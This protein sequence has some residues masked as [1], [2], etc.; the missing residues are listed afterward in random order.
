M[1]IKRDKL[2]TIGNDA[3][4][5]KGTSHGVLTGI[6]YLAPTDVSGFQVC[7]KASEGCK[8]ACLF[9]AGRGVYENVRDGRINRTRWFFEDR[10]SFMAV[11][12]ADIQFLIR[13]AARM[14]A[15]PAVRLN[16]TSDIAWEKIRCVVDGVE[17]RNLM[18]AFPDLQFYDYTKIAG[19]KAALALPNYHLTFSMAEDNDADAQRALA[20]G[21]NVSVVMKL[22]RSEPKPDAWNG[23]PV[24]DG[25]KTD[26]RFHDPSEGGHIIALAAKGKARYDRTGFVRESSII[27]KGA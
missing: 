9:T 10:A 16:G 24:I 14:N 5:Q 11:L 18:V 7:P 27:A 26:I 13:R 25:D 20:E 22:R 4:T 12:V 8:A 23:Y 19:R 21:Y 15:Q 2:L 1:H 6:L 17:Y 3:K